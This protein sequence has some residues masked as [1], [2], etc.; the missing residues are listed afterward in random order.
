MTNR[1]LE[2]LTQ[3]SGFNHSFLLGSVIISAAIAFLPSLGG[4]VFSRRP[5]RWA[6]FALALAAFVIVPAAAFNTGFLYERLGVFLTPLWLMIWNAPGPIVRR[7]LDWAPMVLVLFWIFANVG[8]F[9]SFARETEQ[10]DRLMASVEPGKH[11]ASMVHDHSSPLFA[12]PVY[13][14]FPAW[15]QATRAG[16]VDFNFADFP[17]QM[18]RYKANQGPRINE[19]LGWYP[20]AFEWDLNGGSAYDYFI[21]KSDVDVAQYIFKDKVN[22]VRLVDRSGWWWLYKNINRP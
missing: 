20:T 12:A 1:A 9:A 21:V 3:P 6:P 14:H 5:E 11:V 22:E 19:F 16:I 8:R 13:M 15:Y 7:R 4:S 17:P 2:F 10:F 18:I